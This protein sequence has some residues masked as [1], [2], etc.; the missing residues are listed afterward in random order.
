MTGD[1]SIIVLLL[2]I[3]IQVDSTDV[4]LAAPAFLT[5]VRLGNLS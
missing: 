4:R 3:E 1:F 5:T 2:F